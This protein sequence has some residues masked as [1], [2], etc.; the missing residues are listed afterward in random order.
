MIMV[1]T[2]VVLA[3]LPISLA[4]SASRLGMFYHLRE[5]QDLSPH[6]HSLSGISRGKEL[7]DFGKQSQQFKVPE[8]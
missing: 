3:S 2:K 1:Y 4:L 6:R 7:V 8:T 5:E